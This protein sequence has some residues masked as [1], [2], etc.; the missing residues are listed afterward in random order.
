MSAILIS[1][2]LFLSHILIGV[3]GNYELGSVHYREVLF[4]IGNVDFVLGYYGHIKL[5]YFAELKENFFFPVNL[6]E[7]S[8]SLTTDPHS[9]V[10]SLIIF[11]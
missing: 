3:H 9:L 8:Q 5:A 10:F 2:Y 7:M 11:V 1:L 4:S 6:S